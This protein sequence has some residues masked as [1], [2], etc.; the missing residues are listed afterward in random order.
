[1]RDVE[2]FR[3]RIGRGNM[4]I[5]W[6]EARGFPRVFLNVL[7]NG[8]LKRLADMRLKNVLYRSVM[9]IKIG[10]DVAIA[11]GVVMDMFF[12][13]WITIGDRVIIGFNSTLITHEFLL[14]E[15]RRGPIT[16]GNNV[17]IGAWTLVLPGVKIGDGARVAAYSLVNKDVPAGAFVGGVP[18]KPIRARSH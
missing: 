10:K 12:P 16:I 1:M 6:R 15:W 8:L 9:G 4:L 7:A 3:D 18:A 13:E 17:E 11:Y 14:D 2:I 5:R